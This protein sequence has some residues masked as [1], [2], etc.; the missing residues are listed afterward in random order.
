MV[1][2]EKNCEEEEKYECSE[3]RNFGVERFSF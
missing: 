1:C 2:S 3:K